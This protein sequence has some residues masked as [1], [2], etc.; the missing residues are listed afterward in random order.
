MAAFK[1]GIGT[2]LKIDAFGTHAV[3]QPMVLIEASGSLSGEAFARLP[4]S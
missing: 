4:L 3:S 2:L 1:E